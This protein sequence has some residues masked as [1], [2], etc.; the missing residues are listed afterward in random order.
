[1]KIAIVGAGS[2]GSVFGGVLTSGGSEV[3]LISRNRDHIDWVSQNGLT[4]IEDSGEMLTR[5]YVTDDADSVGFVDL[6]ILLVKSFDTRTAMTDSAGLVGPGT[7]VLSLQNGLGNEDVL[8]ELFGQSRVLFGRTFVGGD[9]VAPGRIVTGLKGKPTI[10]GELNGKISVRSS[11]ISELFNASGLKTE[12]SQNI[13]GV[14]WNKLLVNVSTGALAGITGLSYGY[15][16]QVPALLETAMAAVNEGIAIARARGITL[17]SQDAEAIWLSAGQGQPASFR[18]SILQSLD[19]KSK[20][21]IDFIN[22]ALVR[23]G[24]EMGIATPVN[25]TLVACVKALEYRS[26][27]G[28]ASGSQSKTL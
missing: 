23:L 13:L 7:T 17:I 25:R 4:L 22:G 3:Y 16:Y 19:R 14:I 5:P 6:V 12:I 26:A 11:E 2:L 24:E 18:T 20:T 28:R 1:M 10:I 15:L 8:V 27:T 9:A 21:E